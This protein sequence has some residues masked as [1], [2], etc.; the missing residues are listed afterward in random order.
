[1][2]ESIKKR[3]KRK[4]SSRCEKKR[5]GP[6]GKKSTALWEKEMQANRGRGEEKKIRKQLFVTLKR[7]A[8]CWPRE[9]GGFLVMSSVL[10]RGRRVKRSIV[11]V[12][13]RNRKANRRKDAGQEEAGRKQDYNYAERKGRGGDWR[14]F[15]RGGKERRENRSTRGRK[16]NG[17]PSR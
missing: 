10:E 3:T 11:E 4:C 16:K 13:R 15:S 1:M 14:Q 6:A 17:F 7:G 12:R 9:K 5:G 8:A 2:I